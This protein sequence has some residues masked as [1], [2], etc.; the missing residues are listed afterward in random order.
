MLRNKKRFGI[1]APRPPRGAHTDDD[2]TIGF[3]VRQT[4]RGHQESSIVRY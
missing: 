1:H 3:P 2:K 4:P